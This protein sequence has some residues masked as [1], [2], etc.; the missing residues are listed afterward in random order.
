MIALTDRRIR[1]EI[2][3]TIQMKQFEPLKIG[4]SMEGNIPDDTDP[5]KETEAVMEFLEDNVIDQINRMLE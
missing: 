5:Q 4:L 1:C 2:T 3:K